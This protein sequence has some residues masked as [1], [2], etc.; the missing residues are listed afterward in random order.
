MYRRIGRGSCGTAPFGSGDTC[1]IKREDSD[2]YIMHPGVL[3]HSVSQ[4]LQCQRP[5]VPCVRLK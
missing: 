4:S 5:T 1:A 2:D 3:Q